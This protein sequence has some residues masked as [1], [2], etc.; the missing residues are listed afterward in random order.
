MFRCVVGS[1]SLCCRRRRRRKH[2][3]RRRHRHNCCYHR[4]TTP[5]V[6]I[7][8]KATF[9]NFLQIKCLSLYSSSNLKL[10]FFIIIYTFAHVQNIYVCKQS[11]TQQK[12]LLLPHQ[13]HRNSF[14]VCTH[15]LFSL[16]LLY[17][18]ILCSFIIRLRRKNRKKE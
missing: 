6:H 17:C 15:I 4:T 16:E 12:Y 11:P 3:R 9:Q 14:V 7:G 10:T 5:Y 18:E 8:H 1:L 13:R 2:C